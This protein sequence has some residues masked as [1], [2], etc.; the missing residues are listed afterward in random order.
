MNETPTSGPIR[1][2]RIHHARDATSS[3]HS[4]TRSHT[5]GD[6]REGKEDLF[7]ITSRHRAAG[8]GGGP[9]FVERPLAARPPVA[10]EDESI[11]DARGVADLM[12]GQEQR[13]ALRRSGPQHL[14]DTARLS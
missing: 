8:G 7:Q 6:L 13:A 10:Q 9:Q 2:S 12:D 11:T 5:N 1:T 3:R 4:F 14:R